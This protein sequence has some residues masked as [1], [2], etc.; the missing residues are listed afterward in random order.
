[1]NAEPTIPTNVILCVV[2]D[3]A[4]STLRLRLARYVG[5]TTIEDAPEHPLDS[6]LLAHP[7]GSALVDAIALY[8]LATNRA[9][10]PEEGLIP[11]QEAP[12]PHAQD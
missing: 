4:T 9:T 5:A 2:A 1:M 8:L 10:W 12:T 11:P 7:V 6:D 3:A